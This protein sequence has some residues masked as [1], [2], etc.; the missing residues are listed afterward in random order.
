MCAVGECP[1]PRLGHHLSGPSLRRTTSALS[2]VHFTKQSASA[3]RRPVTTPQCYPNSVRHSLRA[4]FVTQGTRN[5]ADG[6]AIARQTG[7]ASLDSVDFYRRKT[8]RRKPGADIGFELAQTHSTNACCSMR[9]SPS[10]QAGRGTTVTNRDQEGLVNYDRLDKK[11]ENA[12]RPLE[13]DFPTRPEH[14]PPS[15]PEAR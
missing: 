8:P 12:E 14:G 3:L 6:A 4:G 5:G 11:F 15:I 10:R 13:I 2:V 7:H 9:M 1:V